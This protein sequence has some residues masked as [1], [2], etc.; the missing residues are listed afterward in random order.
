[1]NDLAVACHNSS[2]AEAESGYK[3]SREI[4]ESAL[5]PNDPNV[6]VSFLNLSAT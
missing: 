3:Q 5:G 2:F 6:A 4:W 1:L